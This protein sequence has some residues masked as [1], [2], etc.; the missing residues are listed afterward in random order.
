MDC[1]LRI[2]PRHILPVRNWRGRRVSTRPLLRDKVGGEPSACRHRIRPHRFTLDVPHSANNAVKARNRFLDIPGITVE[3]LSSAACGRYRTNDRS[4]VDKW[5]KEGSSRNRLG[6]TCYRSRCHHVCASSLNPEG[7]EGYKDERRTDHCDEE[8]G[9]ELGGRMGCHRHRKPGEERDPECPQDK[10][11]L[12][13]IPRSDQLPF[14]A[15]G[16]TVDVYQAPDRKYHGAATDAFEVGSLPKLRRKG[17][18][19]LLMTS[20]AGDHVGGKQIM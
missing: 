20:I 9:H 12:D 15:T 16:W 11:F 19:K 4:P 10:S 5:S 7:N 18:R 3:F 6:G 1:R 13:S 8:A 14:R 17:T 2:C